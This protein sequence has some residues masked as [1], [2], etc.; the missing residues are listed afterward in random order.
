MVLNKSINHAEEHNDVMLTFIVDYHV[1]YG[2]EKIIDISITD[3]SKSSTIEVTG[4]FET[5]FS[6]ELETMLNS[7]NWNEIYHETIYEIKNQNN[8]N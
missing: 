8:E 6:S 4:L 5:C 7:I 2:I 1:D 3:I